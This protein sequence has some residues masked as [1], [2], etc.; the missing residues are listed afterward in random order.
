MLQIKLKRDG[1]IVVK[2]E[3]V[4]GEACIEVDAFLRNLGSVQKEE[5]TSDFYE[6]EIG[7]ENEIS[8]K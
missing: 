4:K 5:K 3:G 6:T 7:L 8:I 1:K 2:V